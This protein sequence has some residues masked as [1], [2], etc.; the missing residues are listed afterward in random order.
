MFF[1]PHADQ[2]STWNTEHRSEH[3]DCNED[4]DDCVIYSSTNICSHRISDHNFYA[5]CKV[6][7]ILGV[8]AFNHTPFTP[9]SHSAGVS[10]FDALATF[11]FLAFGHGFESCRE[12]IAILHRPMYSSG[13]ERYAFRNRRTIRNVPA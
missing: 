9:V 8:A 10:K 3:F 2:P 1:L 7:G 4:D 6:R 11:G 13:D 12:K 5:V